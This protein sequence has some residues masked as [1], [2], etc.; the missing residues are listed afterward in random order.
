MYNDYSPE[1]LGVRPS[2]RLSAGFLTQA[3]T[4]MVLA[5]LL[6]AFV[7]SLVQTNMSLAKGVIDL[8]LPLMIAE[9]G[10]G[11]GIQ[12]GIRRLSATV[13]LLLFFVY[14]AMMGLTIGVIVLAYTLYTPNGAASVTEA[15]VSAAA[16]FGGAALYG[17]TTKRSLAS[18]GGY[19]I[20]A[21]WG[22]FAALLLQFIF[23][24]TT[25][26]FVLSIAGVLIFTAL[27]AYT[28]QRIQNGEYA[29]YT[30]SMEKASVIGAILLYIEFVNIFL[31]MLRL[32]GGTGSRR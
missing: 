32:M 24:S 18:I 3:F 26:S 2:A 22:L 19:L 6:S 5:L 29:A 12:L 14:A 11:L 7:A 21:S 4:W 25:V 1:R 27:A 20:M 15:F 8:W 16:A 30:G 28:V 17:A 10:L 23:P 13:S 31:F 9:L